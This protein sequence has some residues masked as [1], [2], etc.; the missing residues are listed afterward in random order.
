MLL[1]QE[2]S[3]SYVIQ[4]TLNRGIPKGIPRKYKNKHESI[5]SIS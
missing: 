4:I 2:V 1:S 3:F 5:I